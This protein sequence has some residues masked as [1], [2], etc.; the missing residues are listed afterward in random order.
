[1]TFQIL[2]VISA[3]CCIVLGVAWAIVADHSVHKYTTDPGDAVWMVFQ[4][5]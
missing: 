5:A 3:A 2:L 1:M 4:V